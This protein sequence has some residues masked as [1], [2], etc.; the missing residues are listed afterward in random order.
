MKVMESL[1]LG[2]S[3]RTHK[4]ISLTPLAVSAALAG[5]G[6]IGRPFRAEWWV[7]ALILLFGGTFTA[8]IYLF[9]KFVIS[10]ML[11]KLELSMPHLIL[12]V[13]TLIMAGQP[14]LQTFINATSEVKSPILDYVV[15]SI[16]TGEVP[17]KV[18]EELEEEL[19]KKPV[20]DRLKRVILSLGMGTQAVDFLKDEFEAVME[21]RGEGLNRAIDNLSVIVELYMTAGVFFPVIAIVLL[22]SLSILGGPKSMSI[23]PM[24]ALI[25]FIAIPIMSA[26]ASL[27]AKKTVERAML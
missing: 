24:I 12:R 22:T 27:L 17:E 23:E 14:P 25:V 20:L 26:F 18:M 3:P 10:S 7:S 21:E 8:I 19:G 13:R 9:P 2:G 16:I 6:I 1:Y 5:L 4:V 15:K 11:D